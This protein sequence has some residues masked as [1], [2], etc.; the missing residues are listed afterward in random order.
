MPRT[1]QFQ[2]PEVF[3]PLLKPMRYKGAYGGRGS[4]KSHFFAERLVHDSLY[5]RG[6]CSLCVREVQKSLA[7]SSKKLIETKIKQFSLE[8]AGE[9]KIFEKQI[10]TPGDGVILFQGMQDHTSESVKSFDG[11]KRAWIEEAHMLSDRSFTLLRPTIRDR[12]SEIWA[13]WNPR[14]KTDSI[15]SFFRAGHKPPRSMAVVANWRDNPFFPAELEEERQHDKKYFPERYDHIWEGGYAT[16][17][18]GA[19]YAK[20]LTDASLEG[21]ICFVPRDPLVGVKAFWD[22]GGAGAKADAMAIWIAQFVG[23][24]IRVLDYIEGQSQVLAYYVN[25]LKKKG[26]EGCTCILPHD[27]VNTNNITG[28]RYS[29]HLSEA[30][31]DVP[32]PIPNQGAGAAGMRIE[33]SRRLFNRV[34][35][36]EKTTEAG[37]DALGYYHEKRDPDRNI[38]L[39]PDHD[40]SSHGADAFGLMCMVYNEPSERIGPPRVRGW[41]GKIPGMG[42]LG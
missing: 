31:F 37:R 16:A 30:G 39:G 41:E 19:Y 13:S 7:A 14:R 42:M 32:E 26:Y 20:H 2:V 27:G 15:D 38:G 29:E 12:G 36:N 33:A 28:K 18:V 21:R 11:F 35:F 34:R 8:G 4:G 6:L 1:I 9:F 3:V 10:Q 40:W 17:F 22:I 5:Q 24:E 25:M 23:Y